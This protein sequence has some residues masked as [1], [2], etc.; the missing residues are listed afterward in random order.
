MFY[1]TKM[2]AFK[3]GWEN[4]PA[5]DM[6][7]PHEIIESAR[8]SRISVSPVYKNYSTL[9]NKDKLYS[10]LN[11]NTNTIQKPPKE[12]RFKIKKARNNSIDE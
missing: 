3:Q 9:E 7:K 2:K 4:R 8:S 1:N 6:I 12:E 5:F 11:K 10:L